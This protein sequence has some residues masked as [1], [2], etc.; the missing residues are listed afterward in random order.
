MS[1]NCPPPTST[2]GAPNLGPPAALPPEQGLVDL[3]SL[4]FPHPRSVGFQQ[5]FTPTADLVVHRMPPTTKSFGNL[6][7]P[8]T[9]P[10]DLD[11]HPPAARDVNNARTAPTVG[12]CSTNDLSA[13]SRFGHVQR[14]FR[15]RKRTGR[16][17]AGNPPTPRSDS[18]QTTP[19]RHTPHTP[20]GP[21]GTRSPPPTVPPHPSR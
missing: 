19:T 14:R 7:D 11:G 21:C 8:A 15:H 5:R 3:H 20:D 12:S 2:T 9:Q 16:P 1:I 18:P 17:N 6:I 10:A 13:Q 4:D